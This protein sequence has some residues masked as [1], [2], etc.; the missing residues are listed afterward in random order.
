MTPSTRVPAG[1]PRRTALAR[2]GATLVAPWL[3]STP[4]LAGTKSAQPATRAQLL[5]VWR[6]SGGV[7]LIRHAATE[8]GIGDPPGFV[9]GQCRTQRNLSEAGRQA[10]RA[11]GAWLQV[12]NF[13]PD[14]VRS[15]Q[16]CRC[17]DTARLAFGAFEDWTALNSTF[18]GQGDPAA[19]QQAL[20]E[21]L[22]ALPAGRTEVWVTHQVIMTGLT[23]AYPGLGEGFVV[24]RQGRLVARGD[25][26]A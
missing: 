10:S 15:S 5:A 16:W 1:V 25:L 6:Q 26:A 8:S 3:A 7:L 22:Q 21:R 18:A 14:A 19:Q 20:R 17:Q 2:L 13:K 23:G 11:L 24:D 9:I 12:Q 4:G